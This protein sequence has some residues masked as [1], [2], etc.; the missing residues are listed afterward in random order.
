[1]IQP[2]RQIQPP[3][4]FIQRWADRIIL[5]PACDD[6]IDLACGSGRHGRLF[7]GKA[8]RVLFVDID[9]GGVADLA[10]RA[11]A[12]IRQCDLEG[13]DWPLSGLT[14]RVVTVTNYLWRPRFQEVLD[15]AAPGGWLLYQTFAEENEKYGKPSNPDFLLRDGELPARIGDA[16][17]ID[18]YFHGRIDMPK[19]AVV[20]W[21]AARRKEA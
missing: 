12:E 9:T 7:L 21:L 20:Q 19:P 6:V 5:D 4:P 16:F 11:D 15:L 18:D 2:H 3:L 13:A 8:R 17:T 10:G 1:M 14:A